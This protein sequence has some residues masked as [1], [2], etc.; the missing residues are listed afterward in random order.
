MYH[1]ESESDRHSLTPQDAGDGD[2][3]SG[4]GNEGKG[5]LYDPLRSLLVVGDA[6]VEAFDLLFQP[7]QLAQN[8]L[9]VTAIRF[10]VRHNVRL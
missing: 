4:R 5:A 1:S 6:I 8:L 3:D 7:F 2:R 10:G 9:S